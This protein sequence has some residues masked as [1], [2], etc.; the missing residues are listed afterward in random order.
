[1]NMRKLNVV[2]LLLFALALGCQRD[3]KIAVQDTTRQDAQLLP[4]DVN[5]IMFCDVRNVVQSAL[6]Q[7][8]LQQIE[9]RMREEMSHEK[10]EEFKSATGFDPKRDLHSVLAGVRQVRRHDEDFY[11]VL[12]GQFDEQKIVAF[13]KQ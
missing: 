10:Y 9:N 12:H 2:L 1:M 11:A 7:E 6:A 8:A 5:T 13:I 4:A 3:G